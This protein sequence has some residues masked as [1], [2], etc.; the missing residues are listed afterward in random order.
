MR[1]FSRDPIEENENDPSRCK[2]P[3]DSLR[4]DRSSGLISL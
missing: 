3:E 2:V 4:T 1:L